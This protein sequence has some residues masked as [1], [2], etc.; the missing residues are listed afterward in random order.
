MRRGA[1]AVLALAMPLP[2]LSCGDGSP[3]IY[4][5]CGGYGNA[6]DAAYVL[7]FSAGE[8]YVLA[9]GNCSSFSHKGDSKYAYDFS[10]PIGTAIRAARAGTVTEVQTTFPDGNGGIQANVVA[11]RHSDNTVARYVHLTQGGASVTV[12]VVVTQGQQIAQS[13]NSGYSTGPHLHFEVF[14]TSTSSQSVPVA[15]SNAGAVFPLSAG[16]SI[17][18]Q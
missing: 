14:K 2:L 4:G 15:F 7:P 18:A 3:L 10:M 6:S 17:T 5:T 1:L 16:K 13:G 8:S 9:Q 11:V 12:G